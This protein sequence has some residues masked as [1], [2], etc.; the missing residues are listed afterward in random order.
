[1]GQF[2]II[3]LLCICLSLSLNTSR[4]RQEIPSQP[5]QGQELLIPRM[6]R[7]LKMSEEVAVVVVKGHAT[8]DFKP[9]KNQKEDN[10]GN[11]IQREDKIMK[12]EYR[13]KKGADTSHFF[14][15]DYAPVHRR[16][17]IH[18]KSLPVGP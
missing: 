13:A 16:R 1:M 10:S 9:Q 5:E 2:T 14:T 6:P 8:E 15:M 17:P 11:Q 18:N 3:A 12:Q 7:R 4:A